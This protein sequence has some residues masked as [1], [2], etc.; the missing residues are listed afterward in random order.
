MINNISFYAIFQDM[1][2]IFNVICKELVI[3]VII[4]SEKSDYQKQF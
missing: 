4:E 3:L 1:L 2:C